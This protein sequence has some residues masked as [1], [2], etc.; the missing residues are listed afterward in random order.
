MKVDPKLASIHQYRIPG[1]YLDY[2]HL[3]FN[4]P[5][6]NMTDET[7]QKNMPLLEAAIA[8]RPKMQTSAVKSYIAVLSRSIAGKSDATATRQMR[9]S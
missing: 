9:R 3:D 6:A 8:K 2:E 1:R 7:L 5:V 4:D